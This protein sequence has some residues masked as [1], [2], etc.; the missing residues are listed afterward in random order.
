MVAALAVLATMQYRWLC[1]LSEA[2]QQRMRAALSSGT[3]EVAQ[4]VDREVNRISTNFQSA[5]ADPDEL[6]RRAREWRS[7]AR[8]AP[9]RRTF[10][11]A[12][13]D[14]PTRGRGGGRAKLP[15]RGI[16]RE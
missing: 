4:E 13:P 15:P 9:L 7:N 5:V 12:Q 10:Y 6:A 8:E 16:H 2:E 14:N 11:L 3:H 1:E